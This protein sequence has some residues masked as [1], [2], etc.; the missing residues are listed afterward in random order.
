MK[1]LSKFFLPFLLF[2]C[3]GLTTS[4][5]SSQESYEKG[6]D[7]Y[8]QEN[9]EEA[10]NWY[11]KAAEQGNAQ[12][13]FELADCYRKGEGVS[14][15]DVE[16]VKW[17]R[18]A[19]E[20]GDSDAQFYLGCCYDNGEGVGQN[21]AEAAAWYRKAAEQGHVSAQYYLGVCYENGE[22][23]GQN[24]AEAAAWYRKAA[25][26]GNEEAEEG[27]K[28]VVAK[29]QAI[30]K[31]SGK[32]SGHEWVDLGLPSGTLWAT[33][34]VGASSPEETGDY[35]AWGETKPKDYY[36]WGTYKFYNADD[37]T[38]K[39]YC[40]MIKFGTIDNKKELDPQDDAA[41]ANWGSSWRTPS[42]T[43]FEELFNS[44]YCTCESYTIN[45]VKGRLIT[46]KKNGASIFLP[47][48][49]IHYSYGFENGIGAFWTRTIAV[50]NDREAFHFT[51]LYGYNNGKSDSERC[52]GNSV[53][54]VRK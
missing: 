45:G 41:T 44:H 22:G 12:A 50:G 8:N 24:L 33:C 13:Q 53:R 21:L 2:F 1:H 36:E 25:D 9:F 6:L 18:K 15:D 5:Q 52:S 37:Y 3:I 31:A 51:I 20:Q 54:P 47:L 42:V 46:S 40:T 32:T 23:V 49:G 7:Y 16:A 43:Q 14:E 39:K 28:D 38:V 26:Q 29:M 11:R 48:S 19:A 4:A 35:F 30:K 34:N 17:Y 10:V 27:Y